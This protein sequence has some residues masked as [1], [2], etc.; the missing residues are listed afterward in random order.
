MG[1]VVIDLG[2]AA[3][4]APVSDRPAPWLS[5]ARWLGVVVAL[6]G[7]LCLGGSAP[8]AAPARLVWSPS[9]VS[10][11][12]M[13]A[14]VLVT[15]AADTRVLAAYRIADGTRLWQREGLVNPIF[16][17]VG[18]RLGLGLNPDQPILTNTWLDLA[19][20]RAGASF[21][22]DVLAVA[23]DGWFITSVADEAGSR[24]ARVSP[25]TG[26]RQS[27]LTFA[28]GV[29]WVTDPAARRVAW[30]GTD[31]V[32][33]QR[34]LATG[35]ETRRD[36]GL[37]PG[38][39]AHVGRAS[40]GWLVTRQTDEGVRVTLAGDADLAPRWS[41]VLP[42]GPGL[43]V[44][45]S[46]YAHAWGC[47]PVVCVAS[48]ARGTHVLDLAD[49]RVL[50]TVDNDLMSA[51]PSAWQLVNAGIEGDRVFSTVINMATGELPYP[52]WQ[53]RGRVTGA[54]PGYLLGVRLDDR[55]LLG[56]LDVTTGQ[57]RP[58]PAVPGDNFCELA[59]PYLVC[60]DETEPETVRIWHAG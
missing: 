13:S 51:E 5:L 31:G 24:L 18:D 49:G 8:P 43:V 48:S 41:R 29:L 3:V 35:A 28:P 60:R 19:T 33:R 36:L 9:A 2:D 50:R 26:E 25:D 30:W 53:S 56:V 37:R 59:R 11:Y 55:T 54:I 15:H 58:V 34:D 40:G 23:P 39:W 1:E 6:A 32:L 20:G 47:G 42:G 22:D 17:V 45:D 52:A 12:A 57:L 7:L 4:P 27:L 10:Q 44:V 46:F 16:F 38:S 14:E 21:A